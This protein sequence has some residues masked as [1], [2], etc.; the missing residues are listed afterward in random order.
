MWSL[1]I[2]LFEL[3]TKELPFEHK[4]KNRLRDLILEYNID[5]EILKLEFELSD[6]AIH[7]LK[8]LL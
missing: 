4:N 2:I 1:G 7:L 3:L 5:Y 6:E 8:Q